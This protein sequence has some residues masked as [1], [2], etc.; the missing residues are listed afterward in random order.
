MG[1]RWLGAR[2]QS[3]M[4]P[5]MRSDFV[6]GAA[7]VLLGIVTLWESRVLP[8][9]SL[10]SPGP[11]YMPVVLALILIAAGA[12]IALVNRA[13]PRLAA[14]GWS[15]VPHAT[16]ILAA[17]AFAAMALERLGYRIT[18]A[19]LVLLLL[20][21]VERK[22]TRFALAFAVGLAI[23]TFYLFNT[24]LRVPLPRGPFGI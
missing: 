4:R 15:E 12:L 24:L 18:M 19:V 23:L 9:G 3:I 16:A 20:R 17:G 6:A 11:A 7:L 8:L 2:L 5:S 1:G 22:G 13:G 10:R 21:V 14:L